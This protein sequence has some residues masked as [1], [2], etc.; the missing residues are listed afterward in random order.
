ME[1]PFPHNSEAEQGV[2]GS[3]LIDGEAMATVAE[4]LCPSDFYRDAHQ[5]IYETMLDLYTHRE[6]VDILTLTDALSHKGVLHD[7]GGPAYLAGLVSGVP[8]SG[9]IEYYARIVERTACQRRLIHAGSLIVALAYAGEERMAERAEELIYQVSQSRRTGSLIPI[10]EVMAQYM[11]TLQQIHTQHLRGVVSGVP[12]G[13]RVLDQ[14]LGGLQPSDL[15]TLA[16]RPG[17][18]KTSLALGIAAQVMGDARTQGY[19]VLFF[20]LE[21]GQRQLARRLLSQETGIDQ[22]R[23]RTGWIEEDEWE[24]L[25]DAVG[26]ISEGHLW[27]DDTPALSLVE[28]RTRARRL[29]SEHG[30]DMI[31]VDYMQLMRAALLGGK[32]P[33]NRV[34]E[35]SAISRGLKELARELDVPVLALAQLSRA[36]E[37]RADKV[38]Q[39][40]D[41]RE[42]GSIEADSDVVIFLHQPDPRKQDEES[43]TLH[44]MI[45]KHRNGPTGV[46]PLRFVARLT[47]FVDILPEEEG[48]K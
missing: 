5:R 17:T 12:T 44:V 8:T 7:V 39:L 32:G 29:K 18:G 30:M 40:S 31:I 43:Y 1:R 4:L 28:M 26:H 33:E 3:I 27:I 34:Q 2:L 41:L 20:S 11:T 48:E 21:M 45:A 24:R 19:H 36:V 22:T 23:L 35:V 16:A 6:A 15:I 10:S 13:F 14:L 47:R 42:S 46:I 37:Q 25:Y 9:N 38:P